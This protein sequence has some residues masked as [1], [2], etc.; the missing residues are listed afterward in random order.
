MTFRIDNITDPVKRARVQ[1]LVNETLGAGGVR[2]RETV[3]LEVVERPDVAGQ[4]KD[5]ADQAVGTA[6]L[7]SKSG[8]SRPVVLAWFAHEQVPLPVFE[9]EFCMSRKWRFDLC[10]P[11]R[12]VALECQGGIW[13]QGRHTRG[14]ALLKEWE[15][16]NM[17]AICGWRIL[18]CQPADLC[19]MA[20]LRLI[21]LALFEEIKP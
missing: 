9:Y 16:L 2:P 13:K 10:W 4:S 7:P 3:R 8:Y 20:T 15:K 5:N 14:A 6:R 17:A 11:D 12:K 19:T 1:K 18:Y 21:R